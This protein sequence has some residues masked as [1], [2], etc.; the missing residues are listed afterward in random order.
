MR[1]VYGTLVVSAIALMLLFAVQNVAHVTVSFLTMGATLPLALLIVIAFLG[2]M[3]AG[4]SALALRN[5]L[6][7]PG[8]AP[9]RG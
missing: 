2:G 9:Q 7:R 1:Y 8:R 3:I 4:A 6:H 5:W